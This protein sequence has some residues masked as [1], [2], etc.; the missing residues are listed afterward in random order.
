[1]LATLIEPVPVD[2]FYERYRDRE[3][4]VVDRDEPDR[5]DD[6]LDLAAVERFIFEGNPRD[7]QLRV[8]RTGGIDKSEYLYPSKLVDAVAVGRLFE[9]GCSVVLPHA[10]DHFPPLGRLVRGLE[11]ELGS[12]VQANVY[13]APPGTQAFAPHYDLHD[14][15]AV[16]IHGAKDWTLFDADLPIPATRAFERDHDQPGEPVESYTLRQGSVCYVPRGRIHEAVAHAVSVHI[17]IGIHWVNELALLQAVVEHAGRVVPDLHRAL[18]RGWFQPGPGR[19]AAVAGLRA[20]VAGLVDDRAVDAVL[21]G[22]HHDLV[23]TRQPLVPGQ[24]EQLA[25]I[26]DIDADTVVER[27]RP[28]LWRRHD[29]AGTVELS[30]FGNVIDFPDAV[31]EALDVLLAGAG[32]RVG[33]LPGLDPEEQLVLVR[34][35]IR[36]GVV[37]ARW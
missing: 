28:L 32:T 14:V 25:R 34:R 12:R 2:D 23:A 27:R 22:L 4:F 7:K 6:L 26:D 31:G 16:Q 33:E 29:D 35:L 1:M 36:E 9:Q 20:L 10:H 13:L 37:H 15:I 19:D 30:C 18:P 24:L 8:L 11:A 17:T 5:Y 21:E 3:A